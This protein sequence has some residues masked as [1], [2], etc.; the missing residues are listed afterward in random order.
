MMA[1]RRACIG[2]AR[3]PLPTKPGT[4]SGQGKET[5]RQCRHHCS[6]HKRAPAMACTI[7]QHPAAPAWVRS[8]ACRWCCQAF[9]C[10]FLLFC[11]PVRA[12]VPP[13]VRRT[14]LVAGHGIA[15]WRAEC[16][17]VWRRIPR[18]GHWPRPKIRNPAWS[19]GSVKEK[20]PEGGWNT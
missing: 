20:P 19:A 11:R 6:G 4:G 5:L 3:T 2:R 7:A 12:I 9:R 17:G 15:P 14:G 10:P 13:A 18:V 1:T 16:C 8:E